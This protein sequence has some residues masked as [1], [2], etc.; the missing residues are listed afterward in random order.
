MPMTTALTTTYKALQAM[1]AQIADAEAHLRVLKGAN[2]PGA[3][4]LE[5]D[6][7][8]AKVARKELMASID[9]EANRL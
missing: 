4:K 9:A 7:E 8:K 6:L 3:L 2:M 1:D 5:T